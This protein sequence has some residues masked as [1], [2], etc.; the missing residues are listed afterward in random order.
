M[1]HTRDER[2]GAASAADKRAAKPRS[3]NDE[4]GGRSK[5]PS[6]KADD[7]GSTEDVDEEKEAL[8]SRLD[9]ELEDTFPASDPPSLTQEPR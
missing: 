5:R 9:E 2:A 1:R 3:V 7:R 8:D 6:D 4:P